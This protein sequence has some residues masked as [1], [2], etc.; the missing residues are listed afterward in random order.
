MLLLEWNVTEYDF[1]RLSTKPLEDELWLPRYINRSVTRSTMICDRQECFAFFAH[2]EP[3]PGLH[4][5][6]TYHSYSTGGTHSHAVHAIDKGLPTGHVTL[7]GMSHG[8]WNARELT[9]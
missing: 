8:V 6:T 7:P 9:G 4:A 3:V 5:V 2:T 1:I